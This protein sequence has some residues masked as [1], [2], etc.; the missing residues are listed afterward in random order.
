MRPTP[1][2]ARRRARRRHRPHLALLLRRDP[3]AWWAVVLT[4]AIGLGAAAASLVARAE[5]VRREWGTTVEVLVARRSL[6][7][8]QP[9]RS[10]D[11]E[12]VARPV[13]LV[14][15][16]AVRSLPQGAVARA[17][18]AAGEVIVAERLAPVG[19]R[20]VAAMLPAGTRAMAVPVEPGSTP[21]L[22][23]GDRVE[24]IVA[25][26][27]ESAGSGAPGF[28]LLSDALV[29]AVD[30]ASVTVAVP[31]ASAPRLAVAL[32]LGAV[33]LALIGA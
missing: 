33:S 11:V 25:L 20:G 15:T 18:V 4:V 22:T 21:P 14:P 7:A 5:D 23:P 28:A 2:P 10:R 8:G 26:P 6:A 19:L 17:A 13:A 1:P 29:V 12:L 30:E 27:P 9:V 32:G 16:S 3:R 24:V 31:R